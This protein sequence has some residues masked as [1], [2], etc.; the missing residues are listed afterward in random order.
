MVEEMP[1]IILITVKEEALEV[2]RLMSDSAKIHYMQESL[3]LLAAV[4]VENHDKVLMLM[5]ELEA[6]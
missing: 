4:E 3:L 6:A 2:V 1:D 5:V